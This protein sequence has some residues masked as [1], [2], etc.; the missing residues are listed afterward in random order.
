[1]A[2]PFSSHG[3]NDSGRIPVLERL[4]GISV[5]FPAYN[6]AENIGGLVQRALEVL[7]TVA[8]RF[9]IIVVDD[10]STDATAA[11]VEELASSHPELRLVRHN[12]NKGYGAAL[13][14]GFASAREAIIFFTDGDGQ[15]D[16]GEIDRLIPLLGPAEIAAGYRTE[17]RDP[18]YR[19]LNAGLFN[20]LIR[21]FFGLRHRDLNCAFKLIR[22]EVLDAV[23]LTSNGA[24]INAEL[25]IKAR[26]AGFR[27]AQTGVSHYPRTKGTQTGANP[28]VIIRMFREVF[29]LWLEQKRERARPPRK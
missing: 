9:E 3:V 21:T 10:G 4:P 23:I 1:M 15:F 13:R 29:G 6:E 7:P 2:G 25:L 12:G 24:L 8:E 28:A 26:R 11:K 19:S 17:R 16:I 14:T 5:F 18:L 22:R 27:I 20:L